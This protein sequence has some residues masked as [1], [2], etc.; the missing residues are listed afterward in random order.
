MRVVIVGCGL[1]G[2]TTAYF[3]RRQGC[4]VTVIDRAAGPGRETSFANG[5]MLTPSLADPWN[6]PG[7]CRD[8]LLSFIR[9]DPPLTVR[10]AAL[11]SSMAWG[12]AFLRNSRPARFEINLR[13]NLRLARYTLSVMQRLRAETGIEYT[14]SARGTMKL[15][16]DTPAFER[17]IHANA[18][19]AECGV[20]F[21]ALD[22]AAATRIEPALAEVAGNV[23]GV[24]YYPDDE[25]GDAQRFCEAMAEL[26]RQCGVEFRFGE[27]IEA[28]VQR[29]ARI[30]A[31]R[32]MTGDVAGDVFVLAAGSYTPLL[33]RSV[34]IALQVRPVKGYSITIAPGRWPIQ[35]QIPVVDAGLHVGVVPLGRELRV[36]GMAEFAG[37]DCTLRA[38]RV[39]ALTRLLTAL[40]PALGAHVGA[41]NLRPWTGLRPVSADGVPFIGATSISNLLVNSGHGHLGW[42]LAAGSAKALANHIVGETIEFPLDEYSP[43]RPM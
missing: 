32:T 29:G 6:A 4:D 36:A 24:I 11:G 10:L 2:V 25:S 28:L 22:L 3:L 42:T 30:T 16:R 34:G 37:Y 40:Y 5:A 23:A 31:A 7:V 41:G 21:E 39:R 8:L 43:L 12:R 35:P 38:S 14:Q 1:L 13:R 27:T 19:L 15:F 33:L 17:G 20:R 18:L 26:A 9:R